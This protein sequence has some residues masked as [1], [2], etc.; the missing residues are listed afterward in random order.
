MQM[1][2]WENIPILRNQEVY[3][4]PSVGSICFTLDRSCRQQEQVE[5]ITTAFPLIDPLDA[6]YLLNPGGDLSST[7]VEFENWFID[8]NLEVISSCHEKQIA[9]LIIYVQKSLVILENQIGG[10]SLHSFFFFF[11]ILSPNNIH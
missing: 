5:K 9:Y 7:Q 10:N 4:M 11:R 8:Q 6:F 3:R 1:L 2:P